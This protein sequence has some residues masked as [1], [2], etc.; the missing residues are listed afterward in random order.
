[1]FGSKHRLAALRR[2]QGDLRLLRMRVATAERRLDGRECVI[3]CSNVHVC[4]C[5]CLCLSM[6]V[7]LY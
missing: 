7:V 6:K 3:A 5:M 1:M 4:V 2:L